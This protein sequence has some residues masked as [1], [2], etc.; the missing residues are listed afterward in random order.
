MNA[1]TI[2]KSTEDLGAAAYLRMHGFKLVGRKGKTFYF[3]MLQEE[4]EA[5]NEATFEYPNSPYHDFDANIMALKKLPHF[6][7]SD[8]LAAIKKAEEMLLER[9]LD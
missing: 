3:D 7:P 2:R 1:K 6:I 5:F 4:E 8:S 9:Q